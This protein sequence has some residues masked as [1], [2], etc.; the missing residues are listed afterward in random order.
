MTEQALL[1]GLTMNA[2]TVN[3]PVAS[4]GR[5]VFNHRGKAGLQEPDWTLGGAMSPPR[6]RERQPAAW[7]TR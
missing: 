3:V 7:G 2:R 6:N 5:G 4:S 1:A